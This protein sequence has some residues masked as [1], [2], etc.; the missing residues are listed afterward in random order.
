MATDQEMTDKLFNRAN[1]LLHLA[2][3]IFAAGILW[4]KV[5][6]LEKRFDKMETFILYNG[7][8]PVKSE[9]PR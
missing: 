6:S 7:R 4:Y 8:P 5:D 9:A 3:V 1:T 2:A